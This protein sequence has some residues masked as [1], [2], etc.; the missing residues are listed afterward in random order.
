MLEPSKPV[1]L[2]LRYTPYPAFSLPSSDGAS[3]QPHSVILRH[4]YLKQQFTTVP[5]MRYVYDA[6][7]LSSQ[8]QLTDDLMQR[9]FVAGS[10][11]IP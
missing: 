4:R 3:L 1:T 9:P 6:T 10:N 8:A 5:S 11:R 2:K 7:H